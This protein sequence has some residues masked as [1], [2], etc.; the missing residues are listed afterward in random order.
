MTSDQLHISTNQITL[1]TAQTD[2]NVLLPDVGLENWDAEL[3][4]RASRTPSKARG[5]RSSA[6]PCSSRGHLARQSDITL[7]QAHFDTGAYEDAESFDLL[8]GGM[9]IASGDFDPDGGLDLGLDVLGDD[10]VLVIQRRDSQGRLLDENGDV[11][12]GPDDLS[13][14]GIGRDAEGG[15][16]RSSMV[17][18]AQIDDVTFGDIGIDAG[19]GFDMTR[20]DSPRPAVPAAT[21]ANTSQ[22][23]SLLFDD[24]TP[25]TRQQV[26]EAAQKRDVDAVAK[27][28]KDHRKQLVDRVTE[29]QDSHPG[30][31]NVLGKR[32]V[33]DIIVE[34]QYLPRSRAHARL[35]CID[36]DPAS[37]FGAALG[38]GSNK[39]RGIRSLFAGS[40]LALAPE[41]SSIF[42]IDL[43]AHRAAKRAKMTESRRL[44]EREVGDSTA[45]W[46]MEVGRRALTAE[47]EGMAFGLQE[48][49]D[50][51][52]RLGDDGAGF[53]MLALD[54]GPPPLQMD[55]TQGDDS[56]LRR[57]QR[58][59][60]AAAAALEAERNVSVEDFTRAGILPPLDDRLGT[61]D[62]NADEIQSF[63]PSS[64]RLLAAFE[65]RPVDLAQPDNDAEQQLAAADEAVSSRLA[66]A[67]GWSKN[68]VRAQRVIR[69][70]LDK[71]AAAETSEL[72]FDRV[73]ENASRRA[74]A[75][76]FFEL[77]V[78]G[79]KDQVKL[80]QAEP[81]GDIKVKAKP[82]L[83]T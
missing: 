68:T 14:I 28:A 15:E 79:T 49:G 77:L 57:S 56:A 37:H 81:Y 64:S 72:S 59:K 62:V 80:E 31:V 54:D 8:S 27:A 70:Q 12:E 69:S 34:E 18:M 74:A 44:K 58:T 61:P 45:N 65:S 55:V 42:F 47:A 41:L 33:A 35:L 75:A 40:D 23:A 19:P 22:N 2:I 1:P 60:A 21:A 52:M 29:I 76:F 24:M 82:T 67:Q 38:G 66:C 30:S 6:T 17:S 20:L 53:D 16:R 11:I 78:L 3:H 13:S 26:T 51:L 46:S 50:T 9:G 36:N 7:P 48:G 5:V 73:G 63:T 25:R 4:R 83:W 71:D 32:D 43:D 10:Q 39:D